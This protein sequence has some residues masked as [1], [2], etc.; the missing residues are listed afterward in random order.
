MV[1]GS[2][3]ARPTSELY[4]VGYTN[5]AYLYERTAE[6][7]TATHPTHLSDIVATLVTQRHAA[8]EQRR[9]AYDH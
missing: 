6:S 5:T 2:S 7:D 1:A 4:C 3:P 8:A 9:A